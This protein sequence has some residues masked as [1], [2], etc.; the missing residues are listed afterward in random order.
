MGM[1]QVSVDAI[2][3]QLLALVLVPLAVAQERL[4]RWV[5]FFPRGLAVSRS[6]PLLV[7]LVS[8]KINLSCAVISYSP[9]VQTPNE[10]YPIKYTTCVNNKRRVFRVVVPGSVGA[11]SVF[12][13]GVRIR[14]DHGQ[15]CRCWWGMTGPRGSR[16]G[17]R[18][19]GPCGSHPGAI[20]K[21]PSRHP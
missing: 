11:K 9:V 4:A 17:V 2:I 6:H 7:S 16:R 18:G 20:W 14:S 19:R 12:S 3:G 8:V 5:R 10:K 13:T 15:P 21:Y 1:L